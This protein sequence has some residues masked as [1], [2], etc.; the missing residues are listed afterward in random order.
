MSREKVLPL[1]QWW[2]VVLWQSVQS[3]ST[4]ANTIYM[5]SRPRRNVLVF[6]LAESGSKFSGKIG[7]CPSWSG[8]SSRIYLVHFLGHFRFDL[9]PIYFIH[10]PR[11][12]RWLDTFSCRKVGT[13]IQ[14][15]EQVSLPEYNFNT[16]LRTGCHPPTTCACFYSCIYIM[17]DRWKPSHAKGIKGENLTTRSG[18]ENS[19][20][21]FSWE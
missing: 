8:H 10:V 15:G 21:L 14:S 18:S 20:T 1:L 13:I 12:I 5:Q 3:P 4:P 2:L 11:G 6:F 17:R 7:S 16:E 19:L 9:A